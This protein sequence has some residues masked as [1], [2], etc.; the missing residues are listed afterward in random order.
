MRY[1]FPGYW[2]LI[3]YCPS[4]VQ[5][6]LRSVDA[7]LV[8]NFG[9]TGND[10]HFSLFDAHLGLGSFNYPDTLVRQQ[11]F[12][13]LK[14]TADSSTIY[15]NE[16][17]HIDSATLFMDKKSIVNDNGAS[18]R[19]IEVRCRERTNINLTAGNYGKLKLSTE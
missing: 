1:P 14:I 7:T 8:G 3:V 10:C 11:Y 9:P 17:A 4:A 13:H 18:L 16:N 6:Q 19:S 2:E 15:L 5:I 12:Q